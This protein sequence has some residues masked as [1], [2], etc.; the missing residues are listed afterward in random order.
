MPEKTVEVIGKTF[1]AAYQKNGKGWKCKLTSDTGGTKVEAYGTSRN[2]AFAAA[3][4]KALEAMRKLHR[5]F[6]EMLF[7]DDDP[8]TEAEM[9][10]AREKI[11]SVMNG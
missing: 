5:E 10:W 11:R 8:P 6:G 4:E 3:E 2:K 7:K 9:E 1:Y